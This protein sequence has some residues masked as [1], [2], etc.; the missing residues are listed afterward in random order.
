MSIKINSQENTKLNQSEIADLKSQNEK[1]LNLSLDD[2][3]DLINSHNYKKSYTKLKEL[4][5]IIE[6]NL[7]SLPKIIASRF[8]YLKSI[9]ALNTGEIALFNQLYEQ[10]KEFDPSY[11][12]LYKSEIYF[13]THNNKISDA[14]EKLEQ[15]KNRDDNLN[16]YLA[17]LY[18]SE[19][20]LFNLFE[21]LY[22]NFKDTENPKAIN[23]WAYYY[24]KIGNLKKA[25]YYLE[26]ILINLK[27]DMDNPQ[28]NMGIGGIYF[29]LA[30]SF[31]LQFKIKGDK[32]FYIIYRGFPEYQFLTELV[33]NYIEKAEE[34]FNKAFNLNEEH[35]KNSEIKCL[36]EDLNSVIN[37][38]LNVLNVLKKIFVSKEELINSDI[39]GKPSKINIDEIIRL[40]KVDFWQQIHKLSKFK[41]ETLFQNIIDKRQKEV[42]DFT[43]IENIYIKL[44]QAEFSK[45]KNRLNHALTHVN[46]IDYKCLKD[47]SLLIYLSTF[48][49]EIPDEQ[50]QQTYENILDFIKSNYTDNMLHLLFSLD[51]YMLEGKIIEFNQL[52]R[53]ILD[54]FYEIGASNVLNSLSNYAFWE[55][56]KKSNTKEILNLSNYCI[57]K[58][59]ETADWL[60]SKGRALFALAKF[61]EAK[62]CFISAKEKGYDNYFI[63]HNIG[64]TLSSLGEYEKAEEYLEKAAS[65]KMNFETIKILVSTYL[66]NKKPE[67]AFKTAENYYNSVSENNLEL[68]KQAHEFLVQVSFNTFNNI[69]QVANEFINKYPEQKM[70]KKLTINDLVNQIEVNPEKDKQRFE[71][72]N[73]IT[74]AIKVGGLPC[75]VTLDKFVHFS[76]IPILHKINKHTVSFSGL[77]TNHIAFDK[78]KPVVVDYLGLINLAQYDLF[79][80]LKSNVQKI[81]VP[82]IIEEQLYKE[83]TNITSSINNIETNKTVEI[84]NFIDKSPIKVLDIPA[85]ETKNKVIIDNS[86]YAIIQSLKNEDYIYITDMIYVDKKYEEFFKKE[87]INFL[88]S[89]EF[90]YILF[91]KLKQ[92]SKDNYGNLIGR[93]GTNFSK[94]RINKTILTKNTKVV[95]CSAGTFFELHIS[96]IFQEIQNYFESIIISQK[97]KLELLNI[98]NNYKELLELEILLKDKILKT[99]RNDD[100]F[101]VKSYSNNAINKEIEIYP[102]LKEIILIIQNYDCNLFLDD[103]GAI[104]VLDYKTND[105]KINYNHRNASIYNTLDLL[106]LLDKNQELLIFEK[107]LNDNQRFLPINVEYICKCLE[108]YQYN[109]NSKEIKKI[110]DYY[111]QNF[112]QVMETWNN[113]VNAKEF[114]Y[115]YNYHINYVHQLDNLVLELWL[116]KNFDNNEI[117]EFIQSFIPLY[118]TNYSTSLRIANLIINSKLQDIIGNKYYKIFSKNKDKYI[119]LKN[120]ILETLLRRQESHIIE[121]V[122]K[123]YLSE[124]L[125]L[126]QK[127][128]LTIFNAEIIIK[129][130]C[131][132]LI[133][134]LSDDLK[135]YINSIIIDFQT[136]NNLN[137]V[138]LVKKYIKTNPETG[139]KK[140]FTEEEHRRIIEK[141]SN[142]DFKYK[143]DQ[144]FIATEQ[145]LINISELS[146]LFDEDIDGQVLFEILEKNAYE[147]NFKSLTSILNQKKDSIIS[148][149]LNAQKELKDYYLD[150]VENILGFKQIIVQNYANFNR[151]N[152]ELIPIDCWIELFKEELETV[153]NKGFLDTKN[154]QELLRYINTPFAYSL[155]ACDLFANAINNDDVSRLIDDFEIIHNN[156]SYSY[157]KRLNYAWLISKIFVN[158]QNELSKDLLNKI[159]RLLNNFFEIHLDSNH[160]NRVVFNNFEEEILFNISINLIQRNTKG[161]YDPNKLFL[162]AYYIKEWFLEIIPNGTLNNLDI[163]NDE[164]YKA[165][166][167]SLSSWSYQ[168]ESNKY[169]FS[170]KYKDYLSLLVTKK[171]DYA[172]SCTLNLLNYLKLNSFSVIDNVYNNLFEIS[173]CYTSDDINV[174]SYSEEWLD[175][176]L[177]NEY[178]LYS[179]KKVKNLANQILFSQYSNTI[180]FLNKNKKNTLEKHQIYNIRTF[181]N[182]FNEIEYLSKNI[183]VLKS[184]NY[185]L[186]KKL[187]NLI[188]DHFDDII[189]ISF[190]EKFNLIDLPIVIGLIWENVDNSKRTQFLSHIFDN[191]SELLDNINLENTIWFYTLISVIYQ[192]INYSQ[193]I[194]GLNKI[195]A[196]IKQ[197]QN[198]SA[199]KDA[200]VF[201]LLKIIEYLNI[202]DKHIPIALIDSLI[203]SSQITEANKFIIDYIF[204]GVKKFFEWEL[205]NEQ[206]N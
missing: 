85:E 67:H 190:K 6:P 11:H 91:A 42:N 2:F 21:I 39:S 35:Y 171:Y 186:S 60:V 135:A 120:W 87:K 154:T 117:H 192:Y 185:L 205:S 97:Y 54:I 103:L 84:K 163:N 150:Y 25:H 47:P 32:E 4:D 71:V 155:N 93:R 82:K 26:K 115:L 44:I 64:V 106:K 96:N 143:N 179:I 108:K 72:F 195:L 182:K 123:G 8:L 184:S 181:D 79:N 110:I 98:C 12:K 137:I 30:N 24:S 118:I 134:G 126:M 100:R 142:R 70:V 170:L 139:E 167:N 140:E 51:K 161:E 180:D 43:K 202:V 119:K 169:Y 3:E 56:E 136:N 7:N 86:E 69:Y 16:I 107:L 17:N 88:T 52:L 73:A 194:D 109:I 166:K 157:F 122:I 18:A 101:E 80:V 196:L 174:Q 201:L 144:I 81:F 172:T 147:N 152:F 111:K 99:I 151:H 112:K 121:M 27:N 74:Q 36:Y 127:E 28:T 197:E 33:I 53:K 145:E 178:D 130:I 175:K 188:L 173:D 9:F 45:S 102:I 116:N 95:I 78:N 19:D 5:N 13:L 63:D 160:F 132:E 20:N 94:K 133:E 15:L 55:F 10:L 90:A 31:F 76:S 114:E 203:K 66:F 59:G 58:Y 46:D 131:Y 149:N 48:Y 199:K 89:N 156:V 125:K 1:L 158:K 183:S 176:K 105:N 148:N 75:D 40:N 168:S 49:K 204:T 29:E 206:R 34:F 191:L 14:I 113:N 164:N 124:G 141:I 22:S 146:S 193:K 165:F 57:E 61:K 138:N 153:F 83:I 62:E 198:V 23:L 92:I 200:L 50:N 104:N 77:E 41:D 162:L 129:K 65:L 38:N 177:K 189:K 128:N 159:D 68:K 187:C 37:N